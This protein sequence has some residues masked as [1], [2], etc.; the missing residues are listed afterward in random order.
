MEE[1]IGFLL[2]FLFPFHVLGG[3]AVGFVVRRVIESGFK[4]TS[5]TG[6]GFMLLW[7]AMFGGLPLFFGLAM[8]SGLFF[9]LQL[10]LFLGTAALVAWQ[11]EWL[12]DVYSLPAM[13]L[14][15][16]GLVFLMIGLGV[17]AAMLGT[18]DTTWLF[19]ALLFGGVGGLFLLLGVGLMLRR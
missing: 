4:L 9:A 8:G 3:A 2:A 19:F 12:R 7:G 13:W 1:P 17:G 11:F 16:G 15:S 10:V 6:N 18:G 5:L 14:A